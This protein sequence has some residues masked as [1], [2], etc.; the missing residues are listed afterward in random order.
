M[1]TLAAALLVAGAIWG[2]VRLR[3]AALHVRH[4]ELET[5]VTK[6]TREPLPS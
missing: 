1:G 4:A 5:L 2:G 6:R 3:L